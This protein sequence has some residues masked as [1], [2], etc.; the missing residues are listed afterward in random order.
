M[1]DTVKQLIEHTKDAGITQ[2]ELARLI[3]VTPVAVWR[4]FNGERNPNIKYVE[5]WALAVGC[6]VEILIRGYLP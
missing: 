6:K 3:D 4:W 2:A 5:K 1:T